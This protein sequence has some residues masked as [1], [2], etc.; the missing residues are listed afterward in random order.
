M[1]VNEKWNGMNELKLPKKMQVREEK[2]SHAQFVW[3]SAAG[4]FQL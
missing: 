2:P 1:V 3:E 4:Y